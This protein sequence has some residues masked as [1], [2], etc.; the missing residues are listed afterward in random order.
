MT[1]PRRKTACWTMVVTTAVLFTAPVRASEPDRQPLPIAKDTNWLLRLPK[2]DAVPYKGVVNFDKAGAGNAQILYPAPN[3]LGFLAAVFTHGAIVESQKKNEKDKLQ[4]EANKV[5]VP[6]EAVLKDYSHKELMQRALEKIASGMNMKLLV[7]EEGPGS[8]WTM[9]SIP[10]FSM[11]QDQSAIVLE[12]AIALYPPNAKE[13]VYKNAVRVIS[14]PKESADFTGFWSAKEGAKL[15]EESATLMAHSIEMALK[16]AASAPEA[17]TVHRTFRY[18]EG[19][20]EKIERAGLVSEHCDRA[21][22]KT[23]RG[24]LMSVPT[25]GS[26]CGGAASNAKAN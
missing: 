20:D 3:A 21:V 19:K 14:P 2:E 26:V 8:E 1:L 22:I 7:A 4:E 15:K 23:L 5:L 10:V 17:E 9:V 18:M 6:Y 24:W 11:T 25:T 16:D 12:N 13:P